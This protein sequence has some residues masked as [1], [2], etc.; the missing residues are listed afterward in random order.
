MVDANFALNL[1]ETIGILVGVTIAIL[2]IR[3][4]REERK[5]LVASEILQLPMTIGQ[6]TWISILQNSDFSTY[7]EWSE[8]YSSYAN[9]EAFKDFLAF[10]SI[11]E[12][13]GQNVIDGLVDSDMVIKRINPP[14]IIWIWEK[15]YVVIEEWRKRYGYPYYGE[16]VER[17]YNEAKKKY[18]DAG[19]ILNPD[20]HRLM[21]QHQS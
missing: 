1:V 12:M 2:E 14:S 20:R 15:Y 16:G 6:D 4:N 21:Q 10:W 9:P 17:L 19:L 8:K 18:P 7:E 11:L 13:M 3:R 5:Y